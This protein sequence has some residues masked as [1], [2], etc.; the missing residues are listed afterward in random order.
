V[1]LEN[2]LRRPVRPWTIQFWFGDINEFNLSMSN[3]M[4]S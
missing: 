3:N 1:R 2:N 4:A